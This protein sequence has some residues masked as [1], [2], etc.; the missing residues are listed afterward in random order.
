MIDSKQLATVI[1]SCVKIAVAPH[2]RMAQSS[3]GFQLT[4]RH[5]VCSTFQSTGP[6]SCRDAKGAV[7]QLTWQGRPFPLSLH[8][9]YLTPLQKALLE[10]PDSALSSHELSTE[11][12]PEGHFPPFPPIPPYSP[13]KGT[14]LEKPSVI[15]L[16]F[17]MTETPQHLWLG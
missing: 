7:G 5:R 12:H 16:C 3:H 17:H 14:G 9:R 2:L 13:H 8:V 1:S 15:T 4:G 10:T 11:V 6:H